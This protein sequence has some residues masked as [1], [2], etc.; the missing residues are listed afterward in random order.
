MIVLHDFLDYHARDYPDLEFAKFGDRLIHYDEALSMANR[1]ANALIASGLKKGDRIA[2]LSKN[3]LEYPVFLFGASKAGTPP[4]S[5][6]YR[7]APPEW[8]YIINDAGAKALFVSPH[9]VD[10]INSIRGD[11]ESIEKFIVID[12][13]PVDGYDAFHPWIEKQEDSAPDREILP[14]DD[15]Y[16]MY[17]SG[18]TGHPKG[19]VLTHCAVTMHIHQ[20]QYRRRRE[21]GE[22]NLIVAPMYHAAASTTTS[23]TV[24]SRGAMQ[25]MEDFD[26]VEVVRA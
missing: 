25:I 11:L 21:P 4:V 14:E 13:E 23:A 19:A 2:Y 9:Y 17:T 10:A 5:L 1:V 8:S 16:Q 20:F 6:N 22:Y 15:L 7:L 24:A 3:S 12:H 18:T 26:P